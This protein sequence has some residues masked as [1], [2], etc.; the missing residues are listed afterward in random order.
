MDLIQEQ[1]APSIFAATQSEL[2]WAENLLTGFKALKL[3]GEM[4]SITYH[5]AAFIASEVERLHGQADC[6]AKRLL[7]FTAAVLMQSLQKQNVCMVYDDL[8]NHIA[9]WSRRIQFEQ[10][11]SLPS[12]QEWVRSLTTF[13]GIVEH[14]ESKSNSLWVADNDRVYLR[15]YYEFETDLVT[16]ISQALNQEQRPLS[17]SDL[18]FI[19]SMFD[20]HGAD[21][22]WQRIAVQNALN[23]QFYVITGGPG[24]GKTTTV[25]KLL[26]ALLQQ[27]KQ[28]AKASTI[29]LAAPTGKAA[30]RLS[31]SI[32]NSLPQFDSQLTAN[33]PTEAVTLHRLLRR[34]ADGSFHHNATRP[35]DADVI[36]VDEASMV[37]LSMMAKLLNG[38]HPATQLILLGD[39]NQLSSVEAGSVLSQLCDAQ[40]DLSVDLVTELQKSYRFD[41]KGEIG[42]LATAIK[43]GNQK[44]VSALLNKAVASGGQVTYTEPTV[45][46]TTQL[47]NQVVTHFSNISKLLS[48]ISLNNEAQ[49]IE[50]VFELQSQLQVLCGIKKSEQGVDYINLTFGQAIKQVLN[51]PSWSEHYIGRPIMVAENAYHLSLF[52]GDLGIEALDP[53]SGL[54]VAYFPDVSEVGFRKIPCQRL[55]KHDTVYAMTVHKSQGSEFV[56]TILILPAANGQTDVMTRELLYTGLTRAKLQFTLL[57]E[58]SVVQRA[59]SNKTARSSGIAEKLVLACHS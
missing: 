5:Y 34:K 43:E 48:Q 45:S 46:A 57:G 6:K 18:Q 38:V 39:K 26:L 28:N 37:D 27:S 32:R 22:D 10:E 21:I 12:P 19:E 42:L 24:T 14:S 35:I 51:V 55:P 36:V 33:L 47:K 9:S 41:G 31:E 56:H 52:N 29:S 15:R 2:V 44:T 20:Q 50:Q 53:E 49:I 4:A 13:S 16:R 40:A 58:T 23:K 25:V 54:M 17:A 1:T 30:A 3:N 8:H 7:V 59:I 11:L